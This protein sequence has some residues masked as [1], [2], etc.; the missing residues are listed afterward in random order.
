MFF[1]WMIP[2]ETHLILAQKVTHSE[3]RNNTRKLIFR[4]AN[5][6]VKLVSRYII[7]DVISDQF[8]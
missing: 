7:P 1:L 5:N 4:L 2:R 6:F 8:Q 3:N